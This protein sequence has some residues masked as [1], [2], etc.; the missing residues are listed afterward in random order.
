[1]LKYLTVD[2]FTKLQ[3]VQT[4]KIM[5][6][7]IFLAIVVTKFPNDKVSPKPDGSIVPLMKPNSIPNKIL[8]KGCQEL[9]KSTLS[10]KTSEILNEDLNWELF[11]LASYPV[12]LECAL[13]HFGRSILMN[14]MKL[15]QNSSH[16]KKLPSFIF[17]GGDAFGKRLEN[18][19][20]TN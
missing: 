1:M 16:C 6:L 11:L 18:N 19:W 17:K 9:I 14:L 8:H 4:K 20:S 3:V 15:K 5:N 13:I 7:L 2:V 10:F 12:T